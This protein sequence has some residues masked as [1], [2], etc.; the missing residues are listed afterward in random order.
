MA[1]QRTATE[2]QRQAAA[3]GVQDVAVLRCEGEMGQLELAHLCEELFRLAHRNY[4]RVVVD[5]SGVD[6]VDYRGLKPVAARARLLKS[7]GGGLKLAGL[8]PYLAAIFR[9]AGVE[10]DF[11][12]YRSAEEAKLAFASTPALAVVRR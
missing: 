4:H 8:T 1:F 3:I 6:H 11:E 5:L 7:A 2:Q 9:A 10:E 12:M